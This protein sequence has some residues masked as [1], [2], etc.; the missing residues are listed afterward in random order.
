M[1]G[2]NDDSAAIMTPPG[3]DAKL[4]GVF[5]VVSRI[6][7]FSAAEKRG[8]VMSADFLSIKEQWDLMAIGFKK[9]ISSGL[10]T[11]AFT[12]LLVGV[13][14]KVI[15]CFGDAEPTFV[16]KILVFALTIG[17]PL[18]YASV[19]YHL[20]QYYTG[21]YTKA[22]IKQFISG[23]IWGAICKIIVVFVGFNAISILLMNEKNLV[24]F[25]L[26]LAEHLPEAPP[27][28]LNKFYFFLVS[29]RGVLETS[30]YFVLFITVAI[31]ICIPLASIWF[32]NKKT[33]EHAG[34]ADFPT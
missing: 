29:M 2:K 9:T 21:E 14:E 31:Q 22:M 27:E 7:K 33:K 30:A 20:G 17:F 8:A 3:Q 34:L 4:D 24:R 12:P 26:F 28:K 1:A 18:S 11:A 6:Q 15:P 13:I 25:V 16:D 10:V 32:Q 5:D 23:V 19:V